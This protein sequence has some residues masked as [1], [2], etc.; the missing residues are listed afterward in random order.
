MPTAMPTYTAVMNTAS[1]P[2]TRVRLMTTSMSYSR[3]L[4]IAIAMATGNANP[5]PRTI[6]MSNVQLGRTD[7]ARKTKTTYR[8]RRE[9]HAYAIH[10]NCWRSSPLARR[11]RSRGATLATSKTARPRNQI[12]AARRRAA[13]ERLER[14]EAERV[15]QVGVVGATGAQVQR[16]RRE[17]RGHEQ[18][19][20]DHRAHDQKTPPAWRRRT[21]VGEEH[22]QP[23]NGARREDRDRT[24]AAEPLC[25]DGAWQARV[26]EQREA[27]VLVL[28]ALQA[29][30]RGDEQDEPS[31]RVARTARATS[32]PMIAPMGTAIEAGSAA[33]RFGRWAWLSTASTTRRRRARERSAARRD[34]ERCGAPRAGLADHAGT[35]ATG[36]PT[37]Y[38]PTGVC[39]PL[40]SGGL[41]ALRVRC[42]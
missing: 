28:D 38:A 21:A 32:T 23:R 29:R 35:P 4:K 1:E 36:T 11:I 42:R 16:T 39:R 40:T 8:R 2:Y 12:T 7:P 26:R 13:G 14:C 34:G 22:E 17:R 9:Q 19:H 18:H 10:F 33:S 15:V 3:Y 31:H 5:K 24:E 41:E 27:S 6:G 30:G 37:R 25:P 20:R